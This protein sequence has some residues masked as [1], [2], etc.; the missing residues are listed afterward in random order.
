MD[1]S[2]DTPRRGES[3]SGTA[4][5]TD[6]KLSEFLSGQLDVLRDRVSGAAREDDLDATANRLREVSRDAAFL[7]DV[8]EEMRER[9]E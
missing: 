8:I 2:D 1:A 4:Y 9:E 3:A 6:R 5:S 7:A